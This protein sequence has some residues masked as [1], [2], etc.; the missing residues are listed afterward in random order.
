MSSILRP[1]LSPAEVNGKTHIN[2]ILNISQIEHI[3]FSRAIHMSEGCRIR[4][5]WK[6]NYWSHSVLEDPIYKWFGKGK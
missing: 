2:F 6:Q 1:D 3:D 5:L 4:P